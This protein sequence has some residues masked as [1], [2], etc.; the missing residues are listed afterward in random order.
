MNKIGHKS[1]Q[2]DVFPV[3]PP[4]MLVLGSFACLLQIVL[5]CDAALGFSLNCRYN[6]C[7]IFCQ[8]SLWFLPCSLK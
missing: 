1:T 7:D 8:L 3:Y 2:L 4:R 5:C 6:L